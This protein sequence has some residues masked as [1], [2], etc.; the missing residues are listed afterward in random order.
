[1]TDPDAIPE[2]PKVAIT[3]LGDIWL[4][5]K[6]RVM[7]G[8]ST[9]AEDVERLKDGKK[10]DCVVT[11]PPYG[12]GFVNNHR[13]VKHKEIEGDSTNAALLHAC[14]MTV[15][16]SKYVF[17]RWDN[18]IEVP[19]PTSLITWVKNNWSMGDL[20]HAHARQTEV[21]LFYPGAQ[22]KWQGERPRD[23]VTHDRTDN[24]FHPTQKPVS[25]LVEVIGWTDGVVYDPFGGSGTTLIAAEQTGRT[26]VLM[27]IDPLY[28]D[29]TVKRWE[30]YTGEK[31]VLE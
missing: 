16:H 12:M 3:K 15:E 9:K 31:A 8:D 30:D 17:C 26:A 6:H 20:A 5:G 10:T 24:E 18:L 23:V 28:V 11:D 27:E 1:M 22:H 29:V 13:K 14:S 25:L 2:P 7:A 19:A 21:I 4:C